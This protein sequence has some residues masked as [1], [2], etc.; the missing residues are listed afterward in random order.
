MMTTLM[1]QQ[2]DANNFVLF[3]SQPRLTFGC[4]TYRKIRKRK[5]CSKARCIAILINYRLSELTNGVLQANIGRL[6][7]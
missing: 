4:R 1:I 6:L 3:R 7:K 5:I 2:Q